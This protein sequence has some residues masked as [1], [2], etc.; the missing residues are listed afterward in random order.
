MLLKKIVSCLVSSSSAGQIRFG[1]ILSC[2]QTDVTELSHRFVS[3]QSIAHL[4]NFLCCQGSSPMLREHL[5]WVWCIETIQKKC[6]YIILFSSSYSLCWYWL[7]YPNRNWYVFLQSDSECVS[8]LT[9]CCE[10]K[11]LYFWDPDHHMSV[12]GNS[13]QC[14]LEFQLVGPETHS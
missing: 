14:L 4:L 13:G 9:P 7:V 6:S 12:G 2:M 8:T 3:L 5:T 11:C 10:Q 1:F